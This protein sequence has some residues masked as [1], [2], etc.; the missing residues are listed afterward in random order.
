MT[1]RIQPGYEEGSVQIRSTREF[2]LHAAAAVTASGNGT[3]EAVVG[4]YAEGILD[5]DITAVSGTS[6]TIDFTLETYVNGTWRT[7]PGVT[8]AQKTAV[9]TLTAAVTNFGDKV[10]LSW[11]VGGTTPSF[12]FKAALIAKT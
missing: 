1:D 7:I 5:I 2:V 4:D 3:V 10:R 9:S 8:L 6:P 11:T 12:T